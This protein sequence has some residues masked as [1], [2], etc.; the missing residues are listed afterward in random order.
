MGLHGKT[1]LITGS[2]SGIG[3]AAAERVAA[4]GAEVIVSGRDR[5]R[6]EQT[7]REIESSGGHARF[8][9]ADLDAPDGVRRLAAVAG[10]VDVLVN[11]AGVFSFESTADTTA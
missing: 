4:E 9:A 7:V 3:R 2:T 1:V 11:N 8:V 6:G 5:T 10:D